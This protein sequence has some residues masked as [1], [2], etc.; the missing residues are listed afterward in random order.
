[1]NITSTWSEAAQFYA[2]HDPGGDVH[3]FCRYMRGGPDAPAWRPMDVPAM[4]RRVHA[5]DMLP[6]DPATVPA[7]AAA[8]A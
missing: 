6:V 3:E 5:D 2:C 7:L 1:M 8:V 4:W